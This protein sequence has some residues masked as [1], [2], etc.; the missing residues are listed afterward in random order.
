[1]NSGRDFAVDYL[2]ECLRIVQHY[3]SGNRVSE[4]VSAMRVGL[5]DGLPVIIP[6][7]L[8]QKIGVDLE[9]TRLILTI[10]SVYRVIESTSKMKLS[11]ITDPFNGISPILDK[12]SMNLVLSRLLPN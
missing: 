11:T 8:R 3:L 9:I 5:R 12:P 2:K 7:Q 4:S 6:F 1:V 10:L